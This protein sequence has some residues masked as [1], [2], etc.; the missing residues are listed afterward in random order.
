MKITAKKLAAILP[1]SLLAT[2]AT[3]AT[4]EITITNLT[5]NSLFTPVV[6]ASHERQAPVFAYG[7]EASAE[8]EAVAEGGDIS[9]FVNKWS[10]D[11]SF[12]DIVHTVTPDDVPAPDFLILPGQ[13][14]SVTIE[15]DRD[16]RFISAASMVL[17][18]N[19]AF[20]ALNGVRLPSTKNTPKIVYSPAYDA[21]SE[22]NDELCDSIPGGGPCGGGSDSPDG[23][24]F[25]HIHSGIHGG[26]DLSTV[27]DWRNP[28]A[29]F[30]ITRID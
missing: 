13:S 17:P 8:L 2:S 10:A 9:G 19:D 23:E 3:A 26:H 24:G 22:E 18:T 11:D 12:L 30:S 5:A 20:I 28:T 15:A 1:L 4:F 29:Q 14:K 21:G 27:Y 16:H 6:V 25:V 7:H